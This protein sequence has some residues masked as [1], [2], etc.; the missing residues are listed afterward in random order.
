[1]R[2]DHEIQIRRKTQKLACSGREQRWKAGANIRLTAKAIEGHVMGL[3]KLAAERYSSVVP[4]LLFG[5]P[6]TSSKTLV[7]EVTFR[8]DLRKSTIIHVK[9]TQSPRK[10]HAKSTQSP[11]KVRTKFTQ[12]LCKSYF[13]LFA[14][15]LQVYST[16][17]IQAKQEITDSHADSLAF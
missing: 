15:N 7:S 8:F 14:R 6:R 1:V 9:S 5:Y 13:S 3:L 4:G 2:V 10:V 11:R 17:I 12:S 16:P